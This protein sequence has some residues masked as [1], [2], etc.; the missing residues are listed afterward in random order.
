MAFKFELHAALSLVGFQNNNR[1]FPVRERTFGELANG[2]CECGLWEIGNGFM[3]FDR[4]H[5]ARLLCCR[6]PDPGNLGPPKFGPG[7]FL[8]NMPPPPPH[9]LRKFAPLEKHSL[10]Y[11]YIGLGNREASSKMFCQYL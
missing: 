3:K 11:R 5:N 10:L 7:V 1:P 6:C 9:P 4:S 8:G 2:L